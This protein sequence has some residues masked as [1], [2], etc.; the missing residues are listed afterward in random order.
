MFSL[1]PIKGTTIRQ[2]EMVVLRAEEVNEISAKPIYRKLELSL[3]I[4]QGR[5]SMFSPEKTTEAS[6]LH[7][8]IHLYNIKRK[9]FQVSQ[10]DR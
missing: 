7:N 8:S 9:H 6:Y 10:F 3:A 2:L 1:V 4:K 5:F